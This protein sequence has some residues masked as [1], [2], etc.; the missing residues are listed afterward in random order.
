MASPRTCSTT[1]ATSQSWLAPRQ[2]PI[3]SPSSSDETKAA[4][5]R[6]APWRLRCLSPSAAS[7][8]RCG[9]G[10]L[11]RCKSPKNALSA[12]RG[13]E[14][15]TRRAKAAGQVESIF[16]EVDRFENEQKWAEALAAAQ[17]AEA[18]VASGE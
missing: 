14:R 17:R 16:A 9:T 13:R 8:G 11:E 7:A 6:S 12:K 5:L 18:A 10:Q 15:D 4:S 1:S 2:R 3:A